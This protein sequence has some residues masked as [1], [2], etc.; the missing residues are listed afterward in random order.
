MKNSIRN[1]ALAMAAAGLAIPASVAAA[2]FGRSGASYAVV[3]EPSWEH[4]RDRGNHRGWRQQDRYQ[5]R[6][7]YDQR[8]YGYAP[9]SRVYY[10]EPVYRETEVWRGNDDRHYCRKRDGTT[11]LI[12]GAAAGALV[13]RE[14]DSRGKRTLGTILGAAAGALIGNELDKGSKCR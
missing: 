6:D 4:G 5:Q 2:D 3:V 8:N 13:G 9:P 11:G 7:Y 10:D 12:I 1:T 14:V